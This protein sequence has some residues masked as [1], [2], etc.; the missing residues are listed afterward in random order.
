MIFKTLFDDIVCEAEIRGFY[1]DAD[2][3]AATHTEV[4]LLVVP[5]LFVSPHDQMAMVDPSSLI[6]R[7]RRID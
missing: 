2:V 7:A 3:L 1:D 6:F 5:E 4:E